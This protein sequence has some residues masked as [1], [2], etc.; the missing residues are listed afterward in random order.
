MN[1]Y[2]RALILGDIQGFPKDVEKRLSICLYFVH[3]YAKKGTAFEALLEHLCKDR[4]G[5]IQWLIDPL[6]LRNGELSPE[7]FVESFTKIRCECLLIF[8]HKE[9]NDLPY[10]LLAA[11]GAAKA[12]GKPY[13][14][15]RLPM[16]K[17]VIDYE[18]TGQA[19]RMIREHMSMTAATLA[20]KLNRRKSKVIDLEN[21]AIKTR[22]KTY[23]LIAT[24][25][26]CKMDE[27]IKYKE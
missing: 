5:Q 25:L 1:T 6:K 18:E 7:A 19:I 8:T 9:K 16:P 2:G 13:E 17:K 11:I 10:Y 21:G 26:N 23:E 20:K 14:I 3:A 22:L 27:F 15:I 4:Q 12:F 24:A